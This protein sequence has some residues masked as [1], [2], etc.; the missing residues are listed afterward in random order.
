M[1]CRL[2]VGSEAVAQGNKHSLTCL[3]ALA[4]AS[5]PSSLKLADALTLPSRACLVLIVLRPGHRRSPLY[6]DGVALVLSLLRLILANAL[7]L[8]PHSCLALAV[9]WLGC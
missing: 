3:D 1:H 2:A 7:P 6:L 9:L 5:S 4:L 8:L